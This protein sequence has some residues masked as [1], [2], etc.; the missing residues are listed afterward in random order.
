MGAD[1]IQAAGKR[2]NAVIDIAGPV[3][4]LDSRPAGVNVYIFAQRYHAAAA[5]ATTAVF[6]STTFSMSAPSML[7]SWF[8]AAG[9]L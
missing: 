8:R 2:M 3:Y 5:L 7:L 6:L 4:P 1:R 9:F